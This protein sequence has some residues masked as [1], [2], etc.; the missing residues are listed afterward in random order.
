MPE[1]WLFDHPLAPHTR[2]RIGG[3]AAR[4]RE[5]ETERE[6]VA[7]VQELDGRPYK[8][9]GGGA[10]LLVADRGVDFPVLAL[11]S[12]FRAVEVE[13]DAIVA[14][15]GTAL[16]ALVQTARREARCDFHHLEA[17][18]GTVGG[19]LR[20]NAGTRDWG[21]W[22]VVE[23]ADALF[24]GL[25]AVTRLTAAEA[26]PGYR[27]TGVPEGTLF[28]RAR[29]RAARGDAQAVERAHRSYREEKVRN[30]PYDRASC[31]S[32]WKNPPGQSVWRLIDAIGMR[33]TRRGG[34]QISELHANFIL[35]MGGATAGDVIELMRE[36][37]RRVL[38]RF[39]IGLVPE[40]RLWGCDPELLRELGAED[41]IP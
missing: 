23:W 32:V 20:M 5:L 33:G 10:N 28:L 41:Q 22:D 1:P 13:E 31:G 34:A 38:E 2:Y 7:C 12:E 24:P 30:Q 18:P 37:R 16:P 3:A 25:P 8:P 4:F 11:T 21:V 14:G 29:L 15:A 40:V 26:Q 35:N 9:I 27:D 36:T 19:A 6:A 39:G 17:V